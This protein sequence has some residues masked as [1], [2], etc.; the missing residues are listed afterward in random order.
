MTM[1]KPEIRRD[2]PPLYL[3]L[4]RAIGDA[5]N[6]GELRPGQRLPTQRELSERLG[7][8][9]STVTRGYREAERRGLV[10]GEVG[11]GTYVRGPASVEAIEEREEGPID[12]R[13]NTMLPLPLM[14]ELRDS[15]A[16]V[17]RE[18]ASLELF[19]YGPH[20]GAGSH[21]ETGAT[22]LRR[23]GLEASAHEVAVTSGG[24]HAMAVALAT[25]TEP[26]DVVL[27]EEVT[28]AGMRCLAGLLGLRLEPLPTDA[29]GLQP[30]AL[31]AAC[32]RHRPAA[33][34][35]MPTLQNPT[36][37]VMSDG[38]RREIADAVNRA[39][40]VVV[41]DDSY[42]Y[43][44]PE[45]VRLT[46][47]CERGFYVAGTSKSLLPS[48]RVAFLY[49]PADVLDRVG[50]KIAA[51]TYLA[52]PI[53]VEVV[54]RWI[55]DGTAEKVMSWKREE[56]Q[57]RQETAGR[58]L[59]GWE[60]EAHPRSPHGWLHLPE[61]WSTREFARRAAE[62]GVRVTPA[63]V[64]AANRNNVPHAVRVCVGP[65]RSRALLERGLEALAATLRAG[66]ERLEV[67]I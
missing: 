11:R 61:P 62:R 46:A 55:D 30:D 2:G 29:E 51:T 42:G 44:Q 57:A 43:L 60:Y 27:V 22:W 65:A 4:A 45:P 36:A 19:D 8:A 63:D 31:R 16:Q 38:R 25:V 54:S 67:V 41:E 12:L 26:G 37:A 13:P 35:C 20:L 48:L 6:L 47:L 15:I 17:V 50:E 10:R 5:V 52:S 32:E 58:I 34:Y 33:L 49:A 56:V 66:A 28:Y 9:L 59:A 64:F 53:L 21:R 14:P 24:Q 3:A 18:A 7:I 39:G 23:V 40:L 1:W